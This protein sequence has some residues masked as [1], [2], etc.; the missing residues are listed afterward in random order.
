[1][2]ELQQKMID[3][4]KSSLGIVSTACEKCGISRTTHYRWTKSDP[5]YKTAVDDCTERAIDFAESQLYKLISEGNPAATI[6]YLKTKGKNRGYV[7]KQEVEVVKPK[8][9]SWFDEVLERE[10]EEGQVSKLLQ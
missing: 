5:E 2:T 7:E 8:A 4:L 9:L 6:F 3:A 10:T 1:M